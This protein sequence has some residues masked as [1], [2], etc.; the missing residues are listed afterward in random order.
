MLSS[1][2]EL[3]ELALGLEG[4]LLKLELLL[5]VVGDALVALST[6][7]WKT[8]NGLR[9]DEKLGLRLLLKKL[10]LDELLLKLELPLVRA[11]DVLV[12]L[13]ARRYGI[14]GLRLLLK[15]ELLL[16]EAEDVLGAPGGIGN[17]LLWLRLEF[18]LRGVAAR[19]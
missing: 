6:G 8:E 19:V 15:L 13:V 5:A 2:F 7:N 1:E 10:E 18:E 17:G 11:E 4:L 9:E 12:V 16:V 14:L 3:D